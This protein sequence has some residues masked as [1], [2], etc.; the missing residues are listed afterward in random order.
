MF[1][2]GSDCSR[3]VAA[4]NVKLS[5]FSKKLWKLLPL[6]RQG[7]QIFG[8]ALGNLCGSLGW[9]HPDSK[10]KPHKNTK[11]KWTAAFHLLS[12]HFYTNNVPQRLRTAFSGVSFC[13]HFVKLRKRSREKWESIVALSCTMLCKHV[14]ACA[15][16]DPG[17]V[18]SVWP[19]RSL[20]P[21][22]WAASAWPA[23]NPQN[24]VLS[25]LIKYEGWWIAIA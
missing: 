16:L 23:T 4:G 3:D 7:L 9:S 21:K 8:L 11:K 12:L 24:I 17:V 20:Q 18:H 14:Q 6:Q 13:K 1:T 2:M 19:E 22:H 15:S 25:L 5:T 10:P